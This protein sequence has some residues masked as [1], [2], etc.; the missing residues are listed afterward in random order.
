MVRPAL[1]RVVRLTQRAARALCCSMTLASE[2]AINSEHHTLDPA[3]HI[4]GGS[5]CMSEQIHSPRKTAHRLCNTHEEQVGL[6][7]GTAD[8][9]LSAIRPSGRATQRI[10][11][12][13]CA[14]RARRV[15]YARLC[16]LYAVGSPRRAQIRVACRRDAATTVVPRYHVLHV[17]YGCYAY[18]IRTLEKGIRCIELFR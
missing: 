3:S 6:A 8:T 13:T 4:F 7:S 2:I 12:S 17:M 18:G 9:P 5:T 14:P 1:A 16:S 15:L 11:L 10:I